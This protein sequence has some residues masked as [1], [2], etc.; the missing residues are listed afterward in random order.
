M[1][2]KEPG[3]AVA[4]ASCSVC[5]RRRSCDLRAAIG[6]GR[7]PRP[8]PVPGVGEAHDN[9]QQLWR[10]GGGGAA[11]KMVAP[12]KSQVRRVGDTRCLRHRGLW[13]VGEGGGWDREWGPLSR[14]G[15]W[16]GLT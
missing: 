8:C 2:L 9:T 15:R 14:M 12:D 6:A 13:E 16:R 10:G 1:S 11:G 4:E 5:R 3:S 7:K